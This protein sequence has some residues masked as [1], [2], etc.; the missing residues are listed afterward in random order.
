LR[1]NVNFEVPAQRWS[2]LRACPQASNFD[3]GL[4]RLAGK[5]SIEASRAASLAGKLPSRIEPM[6]SR[7]INAW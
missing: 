5:D 2:A 6:R 1:V 7:W 3:V 4:P